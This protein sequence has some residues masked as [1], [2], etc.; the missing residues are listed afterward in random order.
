MAFK[1]KSTG[2]TSQVQRDPIVKVFPKAG[3]RKARVSMVVELGTQPRDD[4]TNPDGTTSPRSPSHQVALFVDLV[5]DVVDYGGEVGEAQY[6]LMLNKEFQGKITGISTGTSQP[7]KPTGEVITSQP[8]QWHANTMLAKV[9]KAIGKPNIAIEDKKDPESLDMEKL[10]NG[11]LIVQ[12]E[13]KETVK[14]KEGKEITYKN[15]NLK[16]VSQVPLDDDD[17]PVN[18]AKLTA[19]PLCITFDTATVEEVK[20]LRYSVRQMIKQAEEY[21]GSKIQKAIEEYEATL[22]DKDDKAEE[23][24]KEKPATKVAPKTTPKPKKEVPKEEASDEDQ[25]PF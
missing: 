5:N 3:P 19:K 6:R 12:I 16:G 17:N 10:L 18:V 21:E 8:Y 13:I 11:A 4:F 9:A 24:P 2:A 22:S 14:E 20:M 7:R 1:P 25:S 23:A 15:V